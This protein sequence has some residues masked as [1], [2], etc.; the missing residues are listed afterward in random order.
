MWHFLSRLGQPCKLFTRK[1]ISFP[2]YAFFKNLQSSWFSLIVQVFVCMCMCM[3]GCI[4][5]PTFLFLSAPT[6]PSIF[7]VTSVP[8]I[9]MARGASE[10]PLSWE[11][12]ADDI[13][14]NGNSAAHGL[15]KCSPVLAVRSPPP[16]PWPRTLLSLHAFWSP[17]V[18]CRHSS[19]PHVCT[20]VLQ[21]CIF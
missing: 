6:W 13:T 16:L 4:C 11:N 18:S 12:K 7:D 19:H 20:C 21:L 14:S 1:D 17:F 8:L 10:K 9:R 3:P 15:F 2:S 5:P